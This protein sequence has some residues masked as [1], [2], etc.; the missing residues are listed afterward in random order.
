MRLALEHKIEPKNM[1]L[2]AMAGIAVLLEKA[3]EYNLPGDLRLDDWRKLDDDK[4]EKIINWLCAGRTSKYNKQ[5][6]ELTRNA[7]KRLKRLV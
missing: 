5:L 1:A 4:I 7:Q 3:E 2:G 6:I